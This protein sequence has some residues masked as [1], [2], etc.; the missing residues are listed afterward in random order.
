MKYKIQLILV[1]LALFL[2]GCNT[3]N[4]ILQDNRVTITGSGN[5]VSKEIPMTGFDQVEA[6]LI[7]NVVIRQGEDYRVVIFADDNFIDFI[8]LD[9]VESTLSIGLKPDYAYDISQVTMRVEVTMPK[10][11][12]I[13]LSASSR[14]T[15]AGFHS[16]EEFEAELSGS[17]ALEGE[18]HA[19]SANFNLSGST[20]VKLEGSGTSLRVDTCGNSIA[21]LGDYIIKEAALHAA[22]ASTTVV[23]RVFYIGQPESSS[24]SA[25][26]HA[27]VQKQ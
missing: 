3:E 11:A 8:Q 13:R 21:D 7:F 10:L 12:G 22:C 15:L 5:V 26:Q 19:E 14:A 24:I 6:S 23:A 25:L 1:I 9:K 2:T 18:F 16:V 27:S 17:S 4:R 20:Y